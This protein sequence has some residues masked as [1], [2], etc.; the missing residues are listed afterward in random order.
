MILYITII[1]PFSFEEASSCFVGYNYDDILNQIKTK[2]EL[3]DLEIDDFNV[4]EDII[5]GNEYIEYLDCSA[6]IET[7][8]KEINIP[9]NI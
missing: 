9:N 8:I 3:S 1:K 2:Y 4:L 5:N 7:F 6:S